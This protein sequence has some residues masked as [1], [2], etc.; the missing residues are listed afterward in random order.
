MTTDENERLRAM[1]RSELTEALA[2]R[3]PH[4]TAM[5]TDFVDMASVLSLY[6][7]D[8]SSFSRMLAQL[9]EDVAQET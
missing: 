6:W 5:D 2:E 4:R 1:D 3:W 7:T 8:S 9:D